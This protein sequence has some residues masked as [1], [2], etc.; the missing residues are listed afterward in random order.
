MEQ[1]QQLQ[2]H[3]HPEGV[4]HCSSVLLVHDLQV[5]RRI[6]R[7]EGPPADEPRGW[8]RGTERASCRSCRVVGEVVRRAGVSLLF[9][10]LAPLVRIS[11]FSWVFRKSREVRV[12][13]QVSGARIY[14]I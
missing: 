7:A 8:T 10:A 14:I 1:H 5:C 13:T 6:R 4:H 9:F 2:L 3:R 12:R 11:I